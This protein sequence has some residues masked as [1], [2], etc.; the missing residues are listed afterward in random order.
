MDTPLE[1]KDKVQYLGVRFH[2]KM[3]WK[4]QIKNITQTVHLKLGKIKTIAS[5]LTSHIAKVMV[6][7]MLEH[8]VCPIAW[9]KQNLLRATKYTKL[10]LLLPIQSNP[11]NQ[12]LFARSC[13]V[14]K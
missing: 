9:G 3:R 6:N 13:T 14:N 7:A 12:I 8:K 10:V 4:Y 1:R 5:F 2:E 11:L